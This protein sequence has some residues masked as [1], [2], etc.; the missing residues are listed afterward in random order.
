MYIEGQCCDYRYVYH[1]SGPTASE[2]VARLSEDGTSSGGNASDKASM[3]SGALLGPLDAIK[4]RLLAADG[5]RTQHAE[6]GHA[7]DKAAMLKR[8]TDLGRPLLPNAFAMALM[9]GSAIAYVPAP[10][11]H[12]M[13]EGSPIADIYRVF[14]PMQQIPQ[15]LDCL[16]MVPDFFLI[17]SIYLML[18]KQGNSPVCDVRRQFR[19]L[20]I[21]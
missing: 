20:K 13:A 17:A 19:M 3:Y 14:S 6:R 5:D 18:L 10:L 11:Q 1:G 15:P 21:S 9:P 8:N 12:L 7:G 16:L 4:Q 2:F